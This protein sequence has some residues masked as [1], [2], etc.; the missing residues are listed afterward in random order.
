MGLKKILTRDDLSPNLIPAQV[1]ALISFMLHDAKIGQTPLLSI[2]VIIIMR[3]LLISQLEAEGVG[4]LHVLDALLD[5]LR[6]R[7]RM[8][9]PA[10]RHQVLYALGFVVLPDQGVG[11]G[12]AGQIHPVGEL[13]VEVAV[14]E[15]VVVA[16]VVV[17]VVEAEAV[18]FGDVEDVA[19]VVGLFEVRWPGWRVPNGSFGRGERREKDEEEKEGDDGCGNVGI[20]FMEIGLL[21]RIFVSR[22]CMC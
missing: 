22:E 21:I 15:L 6:S 10:V 12:I 9:V 18:A 1:H 19:P 13:V 4:E 20:H 5:L 8:R 14:V 2:K 16:L 11:V 7:R 17:I 3:M